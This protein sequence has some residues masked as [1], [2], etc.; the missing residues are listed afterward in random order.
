M[1]T[2]TQQGVFTNAARKLKWV[3]GGTATEIP[4]IV[5]EEQPESKDTRFFN[6]KDVALVG[7]TYVPYENGLVLAQAMGYRVETKMFH[8]NEVS[9]QL[10]SALTAIKNC[11][12][13]IAAGANLLFQIIEPDGETYYTYADVKNVKSIAGDTA[14]E[15][16]LTFEMR[17]TGRPFTSLESGS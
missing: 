16:Q 7:S 5:F 8:A 1:S 4:V 6:S 13:S 14:A 17:R 12:N 15:A 3:S 2:Y 9:P 10:D 11:K